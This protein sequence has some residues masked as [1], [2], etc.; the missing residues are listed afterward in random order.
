M[1][2]STGK[3]PP[4]FQHHSYNPSHHA[5][6]LASGTAPG[7]SP[8]PVGGT[9]GVGGSLITGMMM[10]RQQVHQGDQARSTTIPSST[11]PSSPHGSGVAGTSA[12]AG[13]GGGVTDDMSIGSSIIGPMA[14]TLEFKKSQTRVSFFVF[15]IL[16]MKYF[17]KPSP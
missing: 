2:G 14:G 12:A 8:R 5:P 7:V 1:G 6:P 9:G 17:K 13:G 15:G 16:Q 4:S 11:K 3:S 10:M